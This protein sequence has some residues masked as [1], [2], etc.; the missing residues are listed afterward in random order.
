MGF[1]FAEGGVGIAL[2]DGTGAVGEVSNAAKSV[3]MVEEACA[4]FLH[5]QGFV[6]AGAVGVAGGDVVGA[7]EF[8]QDVFVVVDI[9]VMLNYVF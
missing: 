2:L 6:D 3:G 4:A 9:A 1:D 8:E 7:V 5:H